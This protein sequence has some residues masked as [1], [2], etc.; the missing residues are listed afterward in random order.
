[1]QSM[2]LVFPVVTGDGGFTQP[3]KLVGYVVT[4]ITS[5]KKSAGAVLEMTGKVVWSVIPGVSS[6]TF[7]TTGNQTFDSALS[8]VDPKDLKL[9]E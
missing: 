1:M 7:P 6:P 3:R 2:D 4:R 8:A 9:L 5:V